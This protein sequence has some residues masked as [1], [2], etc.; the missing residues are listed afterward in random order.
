MMADNERRRNY[1]VRMR[2][3]K[4]CAVNKVE[5]SVF[6]TFRRLQTF[7]N[8]CNETNKLKQQRDVDNLEMGL[9]SCS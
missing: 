6:T 9:R 1:Y 7:Y 4:V 8:I 3:W 2:Q 5:R